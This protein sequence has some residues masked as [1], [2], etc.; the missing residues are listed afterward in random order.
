MWEQVLRESGKVVVAA[1]GIES[2]LENSLRTGGQQVEFSQSIL[3][4]RL[5]G[6][7]KTVLQ[8]FFID[9]FE[10]FSVPTLSGSLWNSWKKISSS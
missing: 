2:Q 8:I 1:S 3:Q 10:Q 9:H 7:R 6:R 4:N 5:F